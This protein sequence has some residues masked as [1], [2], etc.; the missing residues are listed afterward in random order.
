MEVEKFWIGVLWSLADS[1]ISLIIDLENPKMCSRMMVQS[2]GRE[3]R[4]IF[5]PENVTKEPILEGN[6]YISSRFY[7]IC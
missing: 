4:P 1:L 3:N 7:S 6:K 2:L 5:G